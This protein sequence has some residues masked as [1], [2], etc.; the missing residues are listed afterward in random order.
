MYMSG[1]TKSTQWH[2]EEDT[3]AAV[4]NVP[5]IL[6]DRVKH[7][8]E[9]A[10]AVEAEP[11]RLPW[12][13]TDVLG[14]IASDQVDDCPKGSPMHDLMMNVLDLCANECDCGVV[15]IVGGAAA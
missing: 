6:R 2:R 9:G 1:K 10:E 13:A 14:D 15:H 3:P 12:V 8:L 7:L 4:V 11:D 5:L